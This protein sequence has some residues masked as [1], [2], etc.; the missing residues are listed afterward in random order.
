MIN[1]FKILYKAL[2]ERP[3]LELTYL[4]HKLDKKQI[5]LWKILRRYLVRKNLVPY[6][7]I[8][9]IVE[10]NAPYL[11]NNLFYDLERL[12]DR[13]Y[14]ERGIIFPKKSGI[15]VYGY[16]NGWKKPE[17]KEEFLKSKGMK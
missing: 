11:S 3:S 4:I 5:E 10:K 9:D 14:L 6:E 15:A 1:P 16:K 2:I 17:T 13:N 12:A 8:I 7:R